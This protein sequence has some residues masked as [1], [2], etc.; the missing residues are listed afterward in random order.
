MAKADVAA[1]QFQQTL[2]EAG[3]A[4]TA[5]AEAFEL[6]EPAEGPLHD[7]AGPAQAGTMGGA[8]PR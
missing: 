2:V 1:R 6:V 5:E 4:F 7:P 8:A 3:S